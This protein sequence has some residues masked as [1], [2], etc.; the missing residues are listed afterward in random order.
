MSNNTTI[1]PNGKV[2]ISIPIPNGYDTSKIVVYR[3]A[4]NGTKTKYDTTINNGYVTFETDHY[5][6]SVLLNLLLVPFALC[7]AIIHTSFI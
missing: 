4:E 7:L 3:I 5:I 1:Q 2:K 6:S